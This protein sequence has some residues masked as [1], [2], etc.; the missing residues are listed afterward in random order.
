MITKE[1]FER[2]E[3][4]RRSGVTNMF[5]VNK[6]CLISKLPRFKIIEVMENYEQLNKEYGGTK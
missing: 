1:E 4:V 2:Y 3:K 6:V 5:N